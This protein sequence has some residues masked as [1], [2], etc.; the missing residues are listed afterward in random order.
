[1]VLTMTKPTFEQCL[2][3][4]ETALGCKLL[5]WQKEHLQLIYNNPATYIIPARYRGRQMQ[6]RAVKLLTEFLIEKENKHE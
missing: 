6:M 4:I 1:M 2:D 3:H 5:D